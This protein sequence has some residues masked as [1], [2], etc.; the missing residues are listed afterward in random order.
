MLQVITLEAADLG[1]LLRESSPSQA[2]AFAR[3][4]HERACA[5]DDEACVALWSGVM[6]FL[7]IE[8]GAVPARRPTPEAA[9]RRAIAL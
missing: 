6:A 9:G 7:R 2:L 1:T 3:A 5:R 8:T 4:M